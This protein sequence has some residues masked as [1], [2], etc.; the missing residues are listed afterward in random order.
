[1]VMFIY[2]ER[3]EFVHGHY[4][5]ASLREA[6]DG[7][8][9]QSPKQAGVRDHAL[10]T[11]EWHEGMPGACPAQ[12]DR[13]AKVLAADLGLRAQAVGDDASVGDLAD[14]RL[15]VRM[16]DAEGRETIERDVLDKGLEGYALGI[17]IAVETEMLGIDIGHHRN[18]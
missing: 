12:G 13:R 8:P 16:I 17:E 5:F 10:H 2:F 14:H 15:D 11:P 4:N 7:H 18:R 1:M 9:R 3:P 6:P